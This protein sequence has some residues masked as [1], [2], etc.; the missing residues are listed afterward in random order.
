VAPAARQVRQSYRL[1][2][3]RLRPC[4]PRTGCDHR[5]AAAARFDHAPLCK[6]PDRTSCGSHGDAVRRGD[7]LDR[8]EVGT[9]L[10]L[11][12][13]DLLVEPDGDL[14][15]RVVRAGER[16]VGSLGDCGSCGH[17]RVQTQGGTLVGF[18]CPGCVDTRRVVAPPPPWP[19]RPATVRMSTPALISPVAE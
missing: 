11:T 14:F 7:L 19:R 1:Y 3:F 4:S 8:R 5:S 18:G 17:A 12:P 9:Y 6:E 10:D 13:C 16:A 2:I 15:V